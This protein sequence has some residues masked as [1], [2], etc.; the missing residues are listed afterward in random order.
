M[1]WKLTVDV[2][3][4]GGGLVEVEHVFYGETKDAAEQVFRNHAEGCEFL[5]PAI[6]DDRV[7]LEFEEIDAD[8]WPD[9]KD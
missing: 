5:T 9:Y 4:Q 7:N 6:L 2:V 3:P 8:E 1:P